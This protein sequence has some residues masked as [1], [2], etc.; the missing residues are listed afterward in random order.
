ELSE[1]ITPIEAGVEFVVKPSKKADYIGRDVLEKQ[2]TTF[3]DRKIIAIKG[4]EKGVFR[5]GQEVHDD[6]K[7][8]K[9]GFV[10]SGTFSPTFRVPIALALIN[11][12]YKKIGDIVFVKVR[13]KFIRGIIVNRPFYEY[14]PRQS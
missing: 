14:H 9:I 8:N 12:R 3:I 2:L 5:H 10:T 6:S 1:S 7:D 4:L 13:N 11:S